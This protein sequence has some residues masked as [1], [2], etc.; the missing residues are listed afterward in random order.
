MK[1]AVMGQGYVGFP[2]AVA[3]AEAGHEVIA[4]EPD[5]QRFE[6]LRVGVSYIE[7]VPRKRLGAVLKSG[8]YWPTREEARLADFDIAVIAVPTPLKD[9]LL[10]LNGVRQA[11][12]TLARHVRKG[13][14]VILESTTHPGTTRKVV[15]P[16]LEALSRLRAG[17][18]FH[19]G[20][21][22]ERVDPGNE[23][24]TL[25]TT[26]KVVS[27]LTEECRARVAE[28]YAG[29]T[30][31]V[32][33]ADSL[34]EAELAKVFEDAFRHV[35]VALVNELSRVAHLLGVDVRH[36]LDL[37]GSKPFGFTKFTPGSGVSGPSSPVDPVY[38]SHHVKTG[39][40]EPF[41][42]V[43]LAQQINDGQPAYVVSRLQD[44]LNT[45]HRKALKDARVL[46]L[47]L[48][49]KADADDTHQ[50]PAAGVVAELE[51]RGALVHTTVPQ[52]AGPVQGR[53]GRLPYRA[54]DAVVL[55]TPHKE[56][57]L[58]RIAGEAVYVLDVLGVMPEAAHI[59]RL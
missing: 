20:Y 52:V 8:R 37:A 48:D 49:R 33:L 7:N 9:R 17:T 55:L 28:F 2:L 14:T 40:D 39:D 4:F 3:A 31:K 5:P 45:R 27:G 10:D 34:E 23:R 44:T 53:R 6:Q 38:L 13:T 29:I 43:E 18:G 46:V 35:N 42:L 58:T 41:R 1:V 56:F 24:W 51:H 19:L 47:G 50:S 16:I 22:P 32:V 30:Q 54:Y 57:D 26:P 36:T 15:L 59:E 25:A 11:A 21:C 12:E